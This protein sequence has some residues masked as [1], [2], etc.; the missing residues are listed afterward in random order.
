LNATANGRAAAPVDDEDVEGAG[1]G[2]TADEI[3]EPSLR[4]TIEDAAAEAF[5]RDKGEDPAG[6]E[7]ER[8]R[9]QSGEAASG[10]DER[11]RFT[12]GGKPRAA[13]E[14][15]QP[16]GQQPA[17]A[18]AQPA[19]AQPPGPDAPPQ[20]W[21]AAEKALWQQLPPQARAAI[22]RREA[23]V[24]RTITTHD[25]ARQVG[26]NFA[27]VATEFQQLVKYRGGDPIALVRETFGILHRLYSSNPQQRAALLRDIAQRQGA[28]LSVFTGSG[29]QPQPGAGNPGAQPPG[30]SPPT[31]ALPPEVARDI[32][33]MRAYISRQQQTEQRQQQEA[34]EREEAEMTQ[35]TATVEAFRSDPAHVHYDAVSDLMVSLLNSGTAGT[36][37][38]AYSLAVRAHPEVSKQLEAEQRT[39]TEAAARQR[40]LAEKARRKGGGVRGAPGRAADVQTGSRGSVRDDLLA[41][42]AEARSRV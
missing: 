4:E 40:T 26:T 18:A 8:N 42:A 27:R 35:A 36:M 2:G 21:N 30:A 15:Q 37:E 22:S 13:G 3:P 34:R 23:E 28:D 5:A 11:G 9:T 39:A 1:A 14:Q 16:A 29:A 20:A 25:Q 19:G 41:A 17:A 31:A 38:E 32:Q 12:Q 24:H 7:G 6:A 33:Q 10:R